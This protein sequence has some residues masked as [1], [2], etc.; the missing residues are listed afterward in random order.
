VPSRLRVPGRA[1]PTLTRLA[2]VAPATIQTFREA[3]AAT[4]P[5]TDVARARAALASGLG[6][7]WS[8]DDADALLQEL[9]G[10]SAVA[11]SH[12]WTIEEVAR[13][14]T[15][16]TD[17]DLDRDARS[18]LAQSVLALMQSPVLVGLSRAS[19]V[20]GERERLLHTSRVLTDARPVFDESADHIFGV[21]VTQ[22]LRLEFFR[23]SRVQSF[24][25]PDRAGAQEHPARTRTRGG[26]SAGRA[27]TPG[28]GGA[29]RAVRSR[30]TPRP[31]PRSVDGP[32][33]T[34]S[35]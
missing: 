12:A 10:L 17:L 3:N 23:D 26:G 6:D 14:V 4:E 11:A 33:R 5:I 20:A 22:T 31:R 9:F 35:R 30:P 16:S 34:A 18:T 1:V 21:V 24:A 13:D 19:D 15:E 25:G 29:L 32:R 28:A 7:D 2:S 27:A 8:E